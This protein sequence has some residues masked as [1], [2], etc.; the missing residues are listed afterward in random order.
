MKYNRLKPATTHCQPTA[1]RQASLDAEA[2]LP[3]LS[4]L[5]ESLAYVSAHPQYA[6]SGAYASKLRQLQLRALALVKARVQAVLRAA[7]AAVGAA[8]AE[9]TGGAPGAARP[10]AAC[11]L[12]C[13]GVLPLGSL[14]LSACAERGRQT[15]FHHVHWFACCC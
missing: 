7:G 8:V 9:A 2:L 4:R 14:R 6:E 1:H 12:A 15:W 11:L 10:A 3:L 5:G 13:Y